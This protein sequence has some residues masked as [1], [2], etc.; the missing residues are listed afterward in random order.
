MHKAARQLIQAAEVEG[1]KLVEIE[2]GSRHNLLMFKNEQGD[3]MRHP[4]SKSNVLNYRDEQ[5]AKAQ[6]RRFARG[7]HHGLMVKERG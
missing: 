4:I 2:L 3:V 5:N 6:F 1:L 7:Q